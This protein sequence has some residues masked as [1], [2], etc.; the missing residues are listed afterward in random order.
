LK[1]CMTNIPKDDADGL[2]KDG[3]DDVNQSS[4][5]E[6]A[7]QGAH[8]D[9]ATPAI[10]SAPNVAPDA[11]ASTCWD[12]I[13]LELRQRPQWCVAGSDKA[14]LVAADGLPR[15]SVTDPSSWRD[16]DAAC[17]EA[18]KHGLG[19]GYVLAA[20]DPFCCIDLDVKD[21]TPQQVIEGYHSSLRSFDSYAERSRSGKGFHIWI[22]ANIGPGRR[23]QGVEVYSQERFI[24]CTGDVVVAR[25]IAARPEQLAILLA[26]ICQ[27]QGSSAR[28]PDDP[29]SDPSW[30]VAQIAL[31]DTMELGRL[32]TGVWDRGRYPSQSEADLALVT[33]LA[34]LTESDYEC[35]EAFRISA[36]GKRAKAARPDYMRRTLALA[37]QHIAN[38]AT[39]VAQGRAIANSMLR[40]TASLDQFSL[41]HDADL[42]GLPH[43]RW[44]VK[45]IIPNSGIGAIY[46]P[47]GS[48]KSFLT[49]DLLAHIS[50]GYN[51]FGHR[52]TPAPAVYVLF[53]G[54]GGIPKRVAAWRV[55]MSRR[56]QREVTSNMVFITDR[57]NLRSQADRDK[58]VATLIHNGWAGGVLCI[59]TLAQ[60]AQGLEENSSEGMGE[61]ISIFGELRHRLGGVV[62]VIH[63][64]GKDAQRGMRGWSGLPAA[65]DFAIECQFGKRKFDR[66]I[67]LAKVKDDESGK[68]FDFSMLPIHLGYDEDGDEVSSLTVIPPVATTNADCALSTEAARDT[69]DDEFVW[70]WVKA[71]VLDGKFP[72]GR[73]LEG[74]R[75]EQM[76]PKRA[77]TQKRLRDATNRLRAASRLVDADEKS[78]SGNSW[79]KAV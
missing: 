61:M 15:A 20:G 51:W 18:M 65:M 43:P 27:E 24:I 41:L 72:T 68:A 10:E 70:E 11:T 52:V 55:A 58:L 2:D 57:M 7:A 22:E 26:S 42:Q 13:P 34:R 35:W 21:E 25:P 31:E 53:E 4:A 78:P 48:G 39:Q 69:E 8:G 56:A 40:P 59:D 16:F 54:Q 66:R 28:L 1:A 32:F 29:D 62:L 45:R 76:A 6:T 17:T 46:G 77:L 50:N 63:H 67:V 14:P 73:S 44:L 23:R 9:H 33:A 71:E 60:A 75:E 79:M 64:T 3:A 37:R 5:S 19:I 74:Q 30:Y 36:L 12:R 47:S 49:L 38:D